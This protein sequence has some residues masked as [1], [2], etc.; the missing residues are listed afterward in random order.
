MASLFIWSCGWQCVC[1]D[2]YL[3]SGCHT[4]KA[5][6]RHLHYKKERLTVSASSPL[7]HPGL[8]KRGTSW[9]EQPGSLSSCV[10]GSVF[11]WDGCLWNGS[12]GNQKV[13]VRH[14]HYNQKKPIIRHLCYMAPLCGHDAN[15]LH[16]SVHCFILLLSF[17]DPFPPNLMLRHSIYRLCGSQVRCLKGGMLR[18]A[19]FPSTL[20]L[21][22]L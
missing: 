6:V 16:S 14:L 9:V 2:S 4:I 12:L 18:E 17:R 10:A 1:W 21:P 5:Y 22:T 13:N 15:L 7:G 11:I 20:C 8:S 3:W 19:G